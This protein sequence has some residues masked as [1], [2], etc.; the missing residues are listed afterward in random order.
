MKRFA[1][2][3]LFACVLAAGCSKSGSSPTSPSD[4]GSTNHNP[5]LNVNTSTTHLVYGG[6]ATIS[7]T[8]TD[9]DGDAVTLSYAATG[10]TT[11]S[12]GPTA[13]TATF[14]AG[15]QWGPAVVT[16]TASD[17]KGGTAQATAAMYIRNPNPPAF[18]IE[19][20]GSTS[21]GG[22][23]FLVQATS[24]EAVLVTNFSCF[25]RD[26]GSTCSGASW[27]YSTPVSLPANQGYTFNYPG[28]NG[29]CAGNTDCTRY[30]QVGIVGQRPEP[31]GGTFTWSI[32]DWAL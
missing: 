21:C 8:A 1:F 25:P 11:S 24:P 27:H 30:W 26:A 22:A 13:T 31:D 14:T 20:T 15:S 28:G 17:G 29:P 16:V 18:V 32:G 10:G 12:S 9:P 7:V 2:L 6:T 3:L 5:T 23:N 19:G 4:G